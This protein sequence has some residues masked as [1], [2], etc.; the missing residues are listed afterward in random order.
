MA[1]RWTPDHCLHPRSD[2]PMLNRRGSPGRLRS[3][4]ARLRAMGL[5]AQGCLSRISIT[6]PGFAAANRE[7]GDSPRLRCRQSA[8]SPSRGEAPAWPGRCGHVAAGRGAILDR[9]QGTRP[10]QLHVRR[11]L[12]RKPDEAELSNGQIRCHERVNKMNDE[13]KQAE[14]LGRAILRLRPCRR[15]LPLDHPARWRRPSAG[16]YRTPRSPPRQHHAGD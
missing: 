9:H 13:E 6:P 5:T 10:T 4:G 15:D 11:G 1:L 7:R 14:P 8:R 2:A 3:R 16:P 12:Q